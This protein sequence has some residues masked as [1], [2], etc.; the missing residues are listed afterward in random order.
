V[1]VIGILGTALVPLIYLF[2]TP[3][4]LWLIVPAQIISGIAWA[5][6]SLSTFNLLL[7]FTKPKTRAT[8]IAQHTMLVAIPMIIAP[9][10]GGILADN[11]KHFVISGIPFVFLASTILRALSA[12]LM[13]Q[14]REPRAKKE[15][16]PLYVFE[17]AISVHPERFA[18]RMINIFLHKLLKGPRY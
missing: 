15:Y 5:G 10:F 8:E 14:I 13:F 12:W 6:V 2:V 7:D 4:T 1:A 18:G 16:H 11:I 9:I 17:R 3:S